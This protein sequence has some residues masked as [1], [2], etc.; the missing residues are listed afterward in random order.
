MMVPMMVS[1]DGTTQFGAAPGS[2]AMMPMMNQFVMPHPFMNPHMQPVASAPS[3]TSQNSA[4]APM[5]F[6]GFSPVASAPAPTGQSQNSNSTHYAQF[7]Q[8]APAGAGGTGA[9]TSSAPAPILPA[10]PGV[11]HIQLSQY[12]MSFLMPNQGESNVVPATN[13]PVGANA[14]STSREYSSNNGSGSGTG[15][16]GGESK[17]G[18]PQQQG[19][20][21]GSNL[22][23]CA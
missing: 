5:G 3:N 20:R 14:A 7:A 16:G 8:N 12:P 15:G 11:Q 1:A 13:A 2:A 19:M 17:V 6:P 9:Q 18:S 22:A 10:P 23:H 4:P 21:G